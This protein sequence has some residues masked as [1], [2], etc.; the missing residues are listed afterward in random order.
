[1]KVYL[2]FFIR[3][4]TIVPELFPA[5]FDHDWEAEY[6]KNNIDGPIETYW[7]RPL[8]KFHRQ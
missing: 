6:A 8:E 3:K 1:M 4:G 5:Y 7:V 2:L